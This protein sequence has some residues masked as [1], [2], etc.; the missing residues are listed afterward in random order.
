[1]RFRFPHAQP[2]PPFDWSQ[3]IVSSANAFVP[4]DGRHL[5]VSPANPNRLLLIGGW[6]TP[7]GWGVGNDVTTNEVFKSDDDGETWQELLAHDD[8]PPTEGAGAR[9]PRVHTASVFRHKQWIY[10]IGGDYE[11][12]HSAVWRSL[13]GETWERVAASSAFGTRT[14][15]YF[16]SYGGNI[17]IMGGTTDVNEP[18][19]HLADVWRS[20]DDGMT[21]T[22]LA[23]PPWSARMAGGQALVEHKGLL[24]LIGGGIYNSTKYDGIWTFDGTTWTEVLPDGHGQWQNDGRYYHNC[25]SL[26]GRLIIVTGVDGTGSHTRAVQV[27][28]DDGETWDLLEHNAGASLW[29]AYS[30]GSHADGVTVY[31]GRIVRAGGN[32]M[33]REVCEIGRFESPGDLPTCSDIDPATGGAAGGT[34][35]TL[36]GTNFE[37]TL[38]VRFGA[39]DYV[40]PTID[41]DEQLT[42]TSPAHAAGNVNVS[43]ITRAGIIVDAVGGFTYT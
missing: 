11:T 22:E 23:A 27:S 42:V 9:F 3:R 38:A 33:D 41:S 12:M 15:Q 4:A 8:D 2:I 36:T 1:M 29:G 30:G 26:Y 6:G 31:K 40:D 24:Y 7:G 32:A 17:Y 20:T 13:D 10:V 34:E 18:G 39:D 21:F 35:V 5:I 14:L 25:V 37:D 16:A 19:D 43:I 28:D